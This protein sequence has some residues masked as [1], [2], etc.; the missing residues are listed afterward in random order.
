MYFISYVSFAVI[1]DLVALISEFATSRVETE[2]LDRCH[3]YLA[4]LTEAFLYSNRLCLLEIER[5]NRYEILPEWSRF[6]ETVFVLR[7]SL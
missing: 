3:L 5:R 2:L 1:F 6:E 4:F 7:L